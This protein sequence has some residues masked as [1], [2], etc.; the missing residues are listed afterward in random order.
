MPIDPA[1]GV[2][3]DS[4]TAAATVEHDGQTYYF[5][6]AGCRDH[7]VS[8]PEGAVKDPHP[9]L[10]TAGG[11]LTQRV[12]FDTSKGEFDLDVSM[13][14]EL[15]V[16]DRSSFTKTLTDED[17]RKFADASGDTNALHLNEAFAKQTRFGR[18]IVHGTLVAGT[19]SAALAALPG[20]TIYLSE[21]L[22]FKRPVDI[23]DTITASCEIVE[24]LEDE[25]YR[26]TTR[27]E[28][29]DGKIAITGTATVLIDPLPKITKD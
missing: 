7:F 19:I 13:E 2:T 11:M 5:C 27:V 22:E 28:D 3:V 29:G 24:E 18:R 26:L 15:G 6:S 12:P 21:N 16:G 8:D 17:V 14:G 23:G 9:H 4:A 25:R 1:C 20:L 10:I